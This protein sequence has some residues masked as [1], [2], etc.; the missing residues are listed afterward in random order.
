[1]AM[2]YHRMHSVSICSTDKVEKCK[3][4]MST[5]CQS[6]IQQLPVQGIMEHFCRSDVHEERGQVSSIDCSCH[7]KNESCVEAFFFLFPKRKKLENE[8]RYPL[9]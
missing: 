9:I 2:L 4:M 6:R 5:N 3:F 7:R 1:M 8:M